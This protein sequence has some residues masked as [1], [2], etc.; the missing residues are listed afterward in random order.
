MMNA[1]LSSN[2]VLKKLTSEFNSTSD[3]LIEKLG[4]YADTKDDVK[5]MPLMSKAT[6]DV[7]GKVYI[8][9]T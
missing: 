5:L 2:R 7:I 6:L 9:I 3:E 8:F 4:S 1:N